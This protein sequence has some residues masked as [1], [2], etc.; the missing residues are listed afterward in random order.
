MS[1]DY[2]RQLEA[3]WRETGDAP[4]Q[5]RLLLERMRAGLLGR[6]RLELAAFL[7]HEAARLALPASPALDGA[8]PTR[9][10]DD[11]WPWGK[12]AAVAGA[13]AATHAVLLAA[14]RDPRPRRAVEA[15]AAWVHCPCEAH[16][17]QARRAGDAALEAAGISH[18]SGQPSSA[19]PVALAA[20]HTAMA[21]AAWPAPVALK[22]AFRAVK[23]A[24]EAVVAAGRLRREDLT[25][26]MCQALTLWALGPEHVSAEEPPG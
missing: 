10:Q 16:V 3:R 17:A 20:H 12:E 5:A 23:Y 7:G 14:A 11:L 19:R 21:A 24:E 1:D 26:I 15:A 18:P 8:E 25:A 13:V 22:H 9:L 2:L 4:D 6:P